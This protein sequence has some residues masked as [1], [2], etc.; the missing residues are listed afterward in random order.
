MGET[1]SGDT[2]FLHKTTGVTISP[3]RAFCIIKVWM[4]DMDF[5][6]PRLIDEGIGLPGHGCL[7]KK[8]KPNY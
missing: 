2:S 6:N 3:K 1:I 4:E 5:Q 8:H 7:F